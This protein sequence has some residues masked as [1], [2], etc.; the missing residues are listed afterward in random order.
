V[1]SFVEEERGWDGMKLARSMTNFGADA[2][3]HFPLLL[4]SLHFQRFQPSQQDVHVQGEFTVFSLLY[5]NRL[6][7]STVAGCRC[8]HR[9]KLQ[10]ERDTWSVKTSLPAQGHTSQKPVALVRQGETICGLRCSPCR[11]NKRAGWQ[12]KH[13]Q[14]RGVQG[15]H[16]T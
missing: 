11:P 2:Q 9:E 8:T 4:H 14:N 12:H 10:N 3:A 16:K 1:T 6:S 13:Y 15:V 5:R 7:Q